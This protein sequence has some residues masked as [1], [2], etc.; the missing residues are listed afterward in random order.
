MLKLNNGFFN[1]GM[2]NA[3]NYFFYT[4][5]IV[6]FASQLSPTENVVGISLH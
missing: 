5:A 2:Q 3:L 6:K 4:I 1:E